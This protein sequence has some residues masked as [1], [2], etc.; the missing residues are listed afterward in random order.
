[1]NR[2]IFYGGKC[3]K[4]ALVKEIEN[5][6]NSLRINDFTF[7]I[8]NIENPKKQ[9]LISQYH[10]KQIDFL[11]S[12]EQLLLESCP[13]EEFTSLTKYWYLNQG[14]SSSTGQTGKSI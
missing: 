5:V 8:S 1:V 9:T 10:N 2:Q 12:E 6:S 3:P 7:D 14:L 13:K 11:S 4:F